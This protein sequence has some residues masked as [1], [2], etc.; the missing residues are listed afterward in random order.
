[1]NDCNRSIERQ[2]YFSVSLQP[3]VVA[4]QWP[5]SGKNTRMLSVSLRDPHSS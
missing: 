5:N 1:M 4:N 3:S 2:Y